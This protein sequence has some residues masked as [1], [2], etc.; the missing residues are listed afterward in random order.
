MYTTTFTIERGDEQIDLEIDYDVAPYYPAQTYGPPENCYPAEGGEIE[1][2]T[3][4]LDGEVFALTPDEVQA[5]ENH[6]YE[7]HDYA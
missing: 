7:H 3:A 4:T 5:V 6:I 1:E 2:L